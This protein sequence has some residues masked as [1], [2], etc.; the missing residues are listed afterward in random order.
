MTDFRQL[1]Q[2]FGAH[3]RDARQPAPAGIEPRRLQVYRELVYNNIESCLANAFPVLRRLSDAAHWHARVRDFC[4]RHR[5]LAPQFHRLPEEF[6]RYLQVEREHVADDPPFL[7]ELAHYE[8]VD[9]ALSISPLVLD[10]ADVDPDGDILRGIPVL[11]PLAWSL[12]YAFPVHRIGPD[13]QPHAPPA[14]P[15]YLVVNRDRQDRVRFLEI[16]PVTARLL[17]SM[18]EAPQ[19]SGQALLL[20]IAAELSHPQPQAV[21]EQGVAIFQQLRERDIVLGTRALSATGASD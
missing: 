13:H 3:L 5:S 12:V 10:A 2:A 1:Q 20:R 14:Q 11:S 6:L 9:L 7:Y 8:W 15:T 18:E 16:N 21:V 19:A 17:A 4:A